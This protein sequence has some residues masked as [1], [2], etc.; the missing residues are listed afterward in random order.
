ML[1]VSNLFRIVL[2]VGLL[3]LF[4]A[5]S[6]CGSTSTGSGSTPTAAPPV[7][8]N[9]FAAAS[10]TN[11]F[12]QVA[13]KFQAA[14]P[15]VT[16]T[17][18]FGGSQALAQQI[19]QGAPA[20]VFASANQKQM[21]VVIQGGEVDAS[22]SKVFAQNLLVVITPKSDPGKI[23]QLQD[24]AKPGLKIVLAAASVPAGQYAVDF[25]GKASADSSFGSS[26]KANVLK[27][28]VSYETDVETVVSK[29]TLGEGDAG[30]VYV[31]D[32]L[33]NTS[34]LGE[35]NIPANLQ[36]EAVYPIAPIKGSKNAAT[37]QQYVDY[38]L[39]SD[40]QAVMNSFGFLPP[41]S[42]TSF[43]APTSIEAYLSRKR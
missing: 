20:D 43:V 7:T 37:A 22:T 25:L 13:T 21:S 24:L 5:L 32:A 34:Q 2:A 29:V 1:R 8:L 35:I 42:S 36:T 28:V 18:N 23:N 3:A 27:N 30:I 19:N 6:A 17:Y 4:G 12:K 39:S 41:P 16:V 26:Y 38:V 9:V 33:A 11:A 15:N 10:L 31:T 14:H 40:G